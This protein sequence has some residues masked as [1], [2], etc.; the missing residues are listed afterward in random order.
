MAG[1]GHNAW[2]YASD[3]QHVDDTICTPAVL[4]P[5]AG[6]LLNLLT[7]EHDSAL[8]QIGASPGSKPR[9]LPHACT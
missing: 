5:I 3:L 8:L 9:R 2:S 7:Q 6:P 1:D 4:L